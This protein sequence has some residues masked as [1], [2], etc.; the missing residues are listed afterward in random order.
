M[1]PEPVA[2]PMY[3]CEIHS[4]YHYTSF[5]ENSVK[6]IVKPEKEKPVHTTCSG[7]QNGE[8]NQLSHTYPGGC[9]YT[10]EED[11]I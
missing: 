8:L 3:Q 1:E 5:M 7:C 2:H 11:Y 4:K 10:K 6:D 9:L